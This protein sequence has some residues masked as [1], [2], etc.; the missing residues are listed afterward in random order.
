MVPFLHL[1][2]DQENIQFLTSRKGKG[3]LEERKPSQ[4][5]LSFLSSQESI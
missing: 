3:S 5:F 4:E 2:Y 1:S